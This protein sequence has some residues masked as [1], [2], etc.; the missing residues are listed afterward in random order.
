LFKGSIQIDA[1]V[2]GD[3]KA[4]FPGLVRQRV[5]LSEPVKPGY[6]ASIPVDL[7]TGPLRKVLLTYPQAS[8]EIEFTAYLDPVTDDSGMVKSSLP[9]FKPIRA[10]ARRRGETITQRSLIQRLNIM[11]TGKDGQKVRMSRLFAGL[12]KE[13]YAMDESEPLYRHVLVEPSLLK[14][15]LRKG[16]TDASWEVRTYIMSEM[17]DFPIPLEYDL[18]KAV[19][20]NLSHKQ[21]PVRMMA[22]YLLNKSYGDSFQVVLDRTAE[23]D[24]H[25]MVR[26]M[27]VSLGGKMPEIPEDVGAEQGQ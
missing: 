7:M 19:S 2:R 23:Y 14:S 6:F 18:T 8:L 20:E 21:W 9:Y 24:K 27:A 5:R 4:S 13:N 3:I 10:V 26:N 16:L 15:A 25:W 22:L 11:S 17:V 1:E 12:L